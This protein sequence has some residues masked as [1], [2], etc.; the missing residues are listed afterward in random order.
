[1]KYHNKPCQVG[2]E[3]YRSQRERN[4][5]QELLLLERAGHIAGL[6]RE[7]PF[8]LAPSVKLIGERRFRPALKYVA[9]YV[10]SEAH[11]GKV[12]IEDAKGVQTTVYRMK[13][14]LMKTVLGLDVVE[15]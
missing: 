14:H 6:K 15:V 2:A 9:D 4:R 12:I 10:Y 5:H 11:T 7:V 13:K 3:K 1:M 8:L